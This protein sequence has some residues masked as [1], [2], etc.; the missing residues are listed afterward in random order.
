MIPAA[1]KRI[2]SLRKFFSPPRLVKAIRAW[3]KTP[4]F[5]ASARARSISI[6]SKRKITIST[7]LLAFS[8]ALTKG[9]TPSPGCVR[10]FNDSP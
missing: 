2:S 1:R 3:T 7:L 5:T 4:R 8:I 9:A 10:S 6:R